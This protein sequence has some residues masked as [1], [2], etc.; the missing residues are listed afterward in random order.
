[1]AG[2]FVTLAQLIKAA[3]DPAESSTLPEAPGVIADVTQWLSGLENNSASVDVSLSSLQDLLK[4]F[5]PPGTTG[6]GDSVLVRMLEHSYPRIA[7]LLT[8]LGVVEYVPT[9]PSHHLIHWD[10]FQTLLTTPQVLFKDLETKAGL[11]DANK[12]LVN[13]HLLTVQL[14]ALLLSPRPLLFMEHN[15]QGIGALPAAPAD[16][17]FDV[18]A[19]S[20][21]KL[22]FNAPL[23]FK[24]ELPS[25]IQGL[26]P[27]EQ[28]VKDFL[29]YLTEHNWPG[30]DLPTLPAP[31]VN[32]PPVILPKFFP[33]SL[34]FG[35]AISLNDRTRLYKDFLIAPGWKVHV[36]GA[37]PQAAT[38][39][40]NLVYDGAKWTLAEAQ[41]AG[42]LPPALLTADLQRDPANTMSLFNAG[43]LFA[44][45]DHVSGFARLNLPDP[46]LKRPLFTVGLR[47]T[48]LRAGLKSEYLSFLGISDALRVSMDLEAAYDEGR[49]LRV[50]GAGGGPASLGIDFVQPIH[51]TI[52]AG[53]TQ[54][55]IEQVR[56]RVE[57]TL[58][59]NGLGVRANA[60]MSVSALLGPVTATI[61]DF[62]AWAGRSGDQ[63]F[64][65]LGP[66][67]VG[68]NIDAGIVQGGGFLAESPPDS[69][70][71]LGALALKVL[72]LGVGAFGIYEQTQAQR[73]SFVVIMGAR[74]PGIQLGF[75]FMLTGIGG[76]VGINRRA[77]LD[78]LSARL[79][80]GAAGNV[81]F[82]EDPVR[83]APALFNDLAAFFPPADGVFLVG[84]TLQLGWLYIVRL[85]LGVLIEL[86]GPSKIIVVGSARAV[87]PGLGSAVPLVY[88][89]I[90]IL[91][92]V[93]FA[94]ALVFFDAS[95]VDSSVLSIFT[96]TGDASFRFSYGASPYVLLSIGG[97]HPS[98]NPEPIKIRKLARASAGYSI[99]AG[100]HIWMRSTF[101]FAFTPNT[102]Q[103][104]G[105]IEAGMDI[106]PVGAHGHFSFDALVQ[107]KPFWFEFNISAGFDIEFDDVTLCSI[108]VDGKASGPGPLVIS[109]GLSFKVLFVRFRFHETFTLGS[110]NGDVQK[111]DTNV[112]AELVKEV[113]R[114]ENVHAE[115]AEH[116]VILKKTAVQGIALVS[117][118]SKI[119][120]TQRLA[121][122]DVRL[123][124][125]GG[126]P[127]AQPYQVSLTVT[128]VGITADPVKDAF[129]IGSYSNVNASEAL[130]N[131]TFNTEKAGIALSRGVKPGGTPKTISITLDVIHIPAPN[132]LLTTMYT[133]VAAWHVPEAMHGAIGSPGGPA[134]VAPSE[135]I[136]KVHD[137]SWLALD[138]KGGVIADGV[139]G[140]G[141]FQAARAGGGFA[142][143]TRQ[144]SLNLAGV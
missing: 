134:S 75:G 110:G 6:F 84:P 53:G 42:S 7:N 129:G 65:V 133:G 130:N 20:P 5:S 113:G 123:D 122:F 34:K 90:D 112:L 14:A 23:L 10:K 66:S 41:P 88:I 87:I 121:P 36:D 2:L 89:R 64:G 91:G 26:G 125:F 71:F 97:F 99:S 107:F 115:D 120:W 79:A 63:N 35:A 11:D 108:N 72:A 37:Q 105:G 144:A 78:Q 139:S 103:L 100:V 17:T 114:I 106:G 143:P 86:P 28:G 49:G 95:L 13:T 68:V 101:Y 132:T 32:S 76:M 77:D 142:V 48:G 51:Q 25:P 38:P 109:A 16:G 136:V 18:P 58:M 12:A 45:L 31:E 15:G 9:P 39:G 1:V 98:F 118:V 59:A 21:L 131:H 93:D 81:L 40:F 67:G 4:K 74:F 62:G 27:N 138:G 116:S 44:E 56:L 92:G 119:N 96:L 104:G 47:I 57:S 80:S 124:R 24:L 117:A 82:C 43:P 30:P 111:V 137:E 50:Q 55:T 127:L 60:R 135:P 19:T 69:R 83:N 22:L 141:A 140:F 61:S 126:A 46:T 54:L 73:T 3:F 52:G 85:D 70:R 8:L 94:A 33:G 29:K 128:D 102:L